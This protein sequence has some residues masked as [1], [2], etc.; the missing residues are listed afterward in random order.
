MYVHCLRVSYRMYMN[1]TSSTE[2]WHRLEHRRT[3]WI[4]LICSSSNSCFN[5]F[6]F[7]WIW[8]IP[9][10]ARNR[11]KL[12]RRCWV[13]GDDGL[14]TMIPICTYLQINVHGKI[15]NIFHSF[16]F[17]I[18]FCVHNSFKLV[19]FKCAPS[20]W[21]CCFLYVSDT[22]SLPIAISRS[23]QV[24]TCIFAHFA[25]G[26]PAVC[27]NKKK[28]A[29]LNKQIFLYLHFFSSIQ[30]ATTRSQWKFYFLRALCVIVIS[31]GISIFFS[32]PISSGFLLLRDGY[33]NGIHAKLWT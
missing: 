18:C 22:E 17:A 33:G 20:L 19:S 5:N 9:R 24:D 10:T 14:M 12:P 30:L 26:T 7:I 6:F 11:M 31:S 21:N 29:N 1:R 16:F 25:I 27:A 32:S 2:N 13:T 23:T 8:D 28:S 4:V 15:I 3:R